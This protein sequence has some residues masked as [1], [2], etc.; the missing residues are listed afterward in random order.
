MSTTLESEATVAFVDLAGFTGLGTALREAA[1]T[2]HFPLV[3]TGLHHGSVLEREDDVFGATVNLAARVAGQ[4]AGGQVLGTE[5]V[6]E[7]ARTMGLRSTD[8]GTFDLRNVTSPVQLFE[9]DLGGSIAHTVVD[10]VCRMALAHRDAAGRLRWDGHDYWFC[11]LRCA[12]AF[13]EDPMTYVS[14]GGGWPAAPWRL[15]TDP[16]R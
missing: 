5:A 1:A 13:A 10:P 15:G 2:E 14:A 11:S 9:L 6:A 4:A 12:A 16:D 3:R 7:A 8:L